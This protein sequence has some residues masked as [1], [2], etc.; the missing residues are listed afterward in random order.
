MEVRTGRGS[1]RERAHPTSQPG[2]IGPGARRQRA[3]PRGRSRSPPSEW[4][5]PYRKT[6][7]P[8]RAPGDARKSVARPAET[9]QPGLMEIRRFGPDEAGDVAAALEI[10]N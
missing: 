9:E 8:L 6:Y 5:R 2:R 7:P 1:S 3:P 4:P 10:R